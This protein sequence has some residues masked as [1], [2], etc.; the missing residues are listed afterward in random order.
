MNLSPAY[1][2]IGFVGGIVTFSFGSVAFRLIFHRPLAREISIV[3]Q[4]I[5]RTGSL[6]GYLTPLLVIIGTFFLLISPPALAQSLV[7]GLS[8][9]GSGSHKATFSVNRAHSIDFLSKPSDL[10]CRGNSP[11]VLSVSP[12]DGGV[13]DSLFKVSVSKTH[14]T[15]YVVVNEGRQVI[16]KSNWLVESK[17]S[18]TDRG[19]LV[20]VEYK[21][22]DT[23]VI[24]SIITF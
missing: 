14:D 3:D 22:K 16:G 1:V 19:I 18:T 15:K 7:T 2:W 17:S 20:H 5:K 23:Q 21:P 9:G 12:A 6:V 4:E 10:I 11:F 13:S 24:Y 8:G